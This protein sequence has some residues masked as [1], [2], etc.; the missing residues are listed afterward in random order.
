MKPVFALTCASMLA[1]ATPSFAFDGP[2]D[3][4]GERA[5][6]PGRGPRSGAREQQFLNR[7]QAR[8]PARYDKVVEIQRD[9]PRL[10]RALLGHTAQQLRA[11][12][13][14]EAMKKVQVLVDES[15]SLKTQLDAYAAADAKAKKRLSP[16]IQATVGRLFEL[17]QQLRREQLATM[18]ARLAR[19]RSEIEEREKSKDTI[20]REF[21]DD[22]L[23]SN[24][25]L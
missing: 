1:L 20:V 15:Y 6:R 12:G 21:T 17:R 25:G 9:R 13:R 10:Y 7:L 3:S 24:G 23:G 22:M 5:E 18:E 8:D 4:S 16:E 14:G 11:G 2:P 19:L